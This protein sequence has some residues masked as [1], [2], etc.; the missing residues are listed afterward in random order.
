VERLDRQIVQ[1]LVRDGRAS[2]RRV[3]EVLGVSEQT[4]ARRYR[5]LRVDGAIRI[6]VAANE[7]ARGLRR[8]FV[9]IQCRPDAALPLAEALA[10][11][12]DVSWVSITSGGSEV[13][14]VAFSDSAHANRSV[15]HRLP[16]T[17]Q[18]LT[19][20]AVTVLHMYVGDDTKWLAFED[21]LTPEQIA[22]L[23]E[24]RSAGPAKTP[25][26]G[27][28]IRDE[29]EPL[30]AELAA[31]GRATVSTLSRATG[32]PQSRVSARLDELLT[33]GTAHV[34]VDLAPARFGFD[35]VAYLWLTVVPGEI[36][37]TGKT[38]SLL[39]ETTFTAAISGTANLLVTVTCRDLE[40]LYLFVTAEIGSLAAIR[41]IE[42]VP[43][44]QRLKQGGTLVRNDKLVFG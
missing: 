40:A 14:C 37:T 2:F 25:R 31:D 17:S 33:T 41:Q 36:E 38:L 5:A 24:G 28:E 15:L 4:V 8:W 11:R 34:A 6:H 27:S 29:D 7:Y 9:R 19:F 3:G 43:V 18:V 30:L 20:N 13:I 10:A 16:K 12:P 23:V 21:P 26:P 1:C 39:P 44:L 32:L 35:A 22:R 42:V